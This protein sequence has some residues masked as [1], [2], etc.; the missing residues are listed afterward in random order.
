MIKFF[1]LARPLLLAAALALSACAA[2]SPI[3]KTIV[4]TETPTQAGEFL[5]DIEHRTFQFFWDKANPKNGLIPDRFP[6]PSFASVAA[7]G[8]ALTAYPIGVERGYITRVQARD[9][10]LTTLKFFR[11]APQGPAVEGMTGFK[12]FYYH[13]LDMNTGARWSNQ[14]ELSTVDTSLLMAGVLFCQSYF[15][16]KDPAETELRKIA[17]G[18]PADIREDP[19]VVAAYLGVPD[20]E[21]G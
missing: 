2:E 8:F 17:D 9:R 7:V 18:L 13:F 10:V 6:T 11:D 19:K 5:D 14:S 21:L 15:D 4:Q 12:G 16:G 3:H 20:D 1:D